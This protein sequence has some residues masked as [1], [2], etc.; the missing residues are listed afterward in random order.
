[1]SRIIPGRVYLHFKGNLYKVINIAQYTETG[2]LL[3]I[4]KRYEDK[5]PTVYAM[6]YGIFTSP[7]D[8][9]RYPNIKQEYRFELTEIKDTIFN[10]K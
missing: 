4:Y 7:V 9:N 1:M 8:H 2:E 10:E 5:F 3:V 6:P